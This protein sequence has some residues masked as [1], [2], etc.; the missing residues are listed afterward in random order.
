MNTQSVKERLTEQELQKLFEV[1]AEEENLKITPIRN[2][3]NN[4]L[5]ITITAEISA[6]L[7]PGEEFKKLDKVESLKRIVSPN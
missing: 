6:K 2:L 4:S 5:H 7:Q 3:A 1:I